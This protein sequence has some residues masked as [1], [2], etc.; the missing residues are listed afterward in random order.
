MGRKKKEKVI[1]N[2]EEG[3]VAVAAEVPIL[4]KKEASPHSYLVKIT[5]KKDWILNI[6]T[7]KYDLKEGVESEV[8]R[9]FLSSLA[10]EGVIEKE[11]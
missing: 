8:P 2:D 3:K 6:G 5:P 10:T 7:D 11:V 1:L 9:P 4:E